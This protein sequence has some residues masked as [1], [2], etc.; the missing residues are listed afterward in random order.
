MGAAVWLS[1][2]LLLLLSVSIVDASVLV[3]DKL[4]TDLS[5]LGALAHFAKLKCPLHRFFF[6]T[7]AF[8]LLTGIVCV[9]WGN[10]SMKGHT[11]SCNFVC[12]N[13]YNIPISSV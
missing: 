5:G 12:T 6:V 13:T 3:S 11:N 7:L 10:G 1:L 4:Y 2:P 8:W 9:Y